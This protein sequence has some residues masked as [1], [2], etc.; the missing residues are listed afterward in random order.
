MWT[1]TERKDINASSVSAAIDLD[2]LFA[3]GLEPPGNAPRR[4]A[5][6]AVRVHHAA[7]ALVSNEACC[8]RGG[9]IMGHVCH[10]RRRPNIAA[11]LGGVL[12]RENNVEYT[13]SRRDEMVVE[14][15]ASNMMR[16]G[17]GP[18]CAKKTLN[19]R[20]RDGIFRHLRGCEAGG[21]TASS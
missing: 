4:S 5:W 20:K 10:K 12:L 6:H 16:M 18:L 1:H 7:R 3:R 14:T 2:T 11:L 8:E 9:S 19:K 15:V 13:D 21:R 17:R